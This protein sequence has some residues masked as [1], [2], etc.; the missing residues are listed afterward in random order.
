MVK[1]NHFHT[2]DLDSL[3]RHLLDQ[4]FGDASPACDLHLRTAL[5]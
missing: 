2:P 4:E 3:E 5:H 1:N